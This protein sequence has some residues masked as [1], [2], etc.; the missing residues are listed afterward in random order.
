MRVA[1]VLCG[2]LMLPSLACSC[3]HALVLVLGGALACIDRPAELLLLTRRRIISSAT[4][5]HQVTR[6]RV[7]AIVGVVTVVLAVLVHIA[8]PLRIWIC[9][10][11]LRLDG[12]RARLAFMDDHLEL[13]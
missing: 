9:L 6:S 4:F 12:V 2:S 10:E 11:G 1:F 8:Q 7:A 13:R 5:H 3:S